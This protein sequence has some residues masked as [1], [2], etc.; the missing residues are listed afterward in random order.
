MSTT[1]RVTDDGYECRTDQS[2][3]TVKWSL[4]GRIVTG[5]EFWL[6]F[7]GRQFMGFLPR[8]A[9]SSEQQA[10]LDDLLASRQNAGIA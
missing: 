9:F 3:T 10:E 8:R 6:F 7:A 4:F 2:T 5:T 1:L